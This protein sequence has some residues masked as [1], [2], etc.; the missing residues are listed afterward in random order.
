[1]SNCTKRLRIEIRFGIATGRKL[2]FRKRKEMATMQESFMANLFM[3]SFYCFNNW[4]SRLQSVPAA[5]STV[6]KH[7]MKWIS[8]QWSVMQSLMLSC[9]SE[10]PV[11]L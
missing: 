7:R 10:E 11:E 5:L 2:E 3:D 8:T 9:A 1:M 4:M 6:N